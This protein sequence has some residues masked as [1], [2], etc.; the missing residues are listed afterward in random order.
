MATGLGDH[1]VLLRLPLNRVAVKA[2]VG[3]N[4][5]AAWTRAR[6]ASAAE[7]SG[8]MCGVGNDSR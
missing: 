5:V 2:E 4:F 3:S 6:A 8:E 1:N 7:R